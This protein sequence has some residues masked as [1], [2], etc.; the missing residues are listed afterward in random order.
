MEEED[1]EPAAEGAGALDIVS[2][3]NMACLPVPAPDA[4]REAEEE[5]EEEEETLSLMD[6]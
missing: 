1:T 6:W 4:G 2:E 3:G 5:E